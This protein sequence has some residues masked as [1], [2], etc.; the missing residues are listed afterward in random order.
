VVPFNRHPVV[1]RGSLYRHRGYQGSQDLDVGGCMI[2]I[3]K[4][5]YWDLPWSLVDGC[6]PCSPGCDHCWSAGMAHRFYRQHLT[7]CDGKFNGHVAVRPERLDI[8]LKRRKP[9]VY[10]VWND[11]FWEGR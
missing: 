9:T 2:N 8:P 11:L 6:T 7:T 3:S 5:R 4:G 1:R 10:A